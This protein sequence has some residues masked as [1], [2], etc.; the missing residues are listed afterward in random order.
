[1]SGRTGVGVGLSGSEAERTVIDLRTGGEV[2]SD[3]IGEKDC[4]ALMDRGWKEEAKGRQD[5]Q[6]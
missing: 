3:P 2:E 6:P 5:Q 4:Q 1:M